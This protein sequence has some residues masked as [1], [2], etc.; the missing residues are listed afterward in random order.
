MLASKAEIAPNAICLGRSRN[1][2]HRRQ[3]AFYLGRS[4]NAECSF[5][6]MGRNGVIH[7][8]CVKTLV[9]NTILLRS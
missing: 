3:I 5:L 7:K 6:Q 1:A 2:Y 4:R 8:P 9:F